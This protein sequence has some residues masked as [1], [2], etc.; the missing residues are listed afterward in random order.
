MEKSFWIIALAAGLFVFF[1]KAQAYNFLTNH[2]AIPHDFNAA[3]PPAG[4]I[5]NDPKF[6]NPIIRIAKPPGMSGQGIAP[7]YSKRQA[8]NADESLLMLRSGDG[9][10]LI[11]DGSSYKFRKTLS[12]RSVGSQD[13]FWH[14]T[15]PKLLYFNTDATLYLYNIDTDEITLV[16]AFKDIGGKQYLYADTLGEGNLSKDGHY[17]AVIGRVSDA[18]YKEILLLDINEKK[19]VARKTMP[20]GVDFVDW[21]SVSPNG[22]YVVVD[23]ALSSRGVEVYSSDLKRLIWTKPLGTGHSDFGYDA[24]GTEVMAMDVYDEAFNKTIF[25][26]FRL[27]DGQETNLLSVDLFDQHISCRNFNRPGWCYISIFDMSDDSSNSASNWLPFADEIFALKL[28]GSAFNAAG[29]VERYAHHY[30]RRYGSGDTIYLAEPHA[31][32]SVKGDRVVFASNWRQNIYS[33]ASVDAYVLDLRAGG[34]STTTPPN[35]NNVS[36][37]KRIFYVAKNGS[38]YYKGSLTKPWRTIAYG[39]SQLKPG[40][41]LCVR[42][43]TYN[44]KITITKSGTPEKPITISA[45]TKES[46]KIYGGKSWGYGV[47]VKKGV[48]NV[49]LKGIKK[50]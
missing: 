36:S 41:T 13:V 11:Y 4:Q 22:D 9:K 37:T 12:D 6:N 3:K 50:K 39:L 24:D 40:D 33:E 28:D 47:V 26:K 2:N 32:V 38:N 29:G 16:Y 7:E 21:V 49:V 23:Y 27:S 43:G 17:Y 20:G 34:R 18:V 8:F 46:V 48:H 31:T 14:S 25:K 42:Q 30:S 19:V 44:E 35:G 10:I 45:H 1:T 5:F 15:N